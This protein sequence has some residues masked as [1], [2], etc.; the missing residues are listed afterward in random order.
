MLLQKRRRP[1]L[2]SM[3]APGPRVKRT[4]PIVDP[5]LATVNHSAALVRHSPPLSESVLR[6]DAASRLACHLSLA[7][8]WPGLTLLVLAV[9]LIASVLLGLLLGGGWS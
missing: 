6:A 5:R 8:Y 3:G 2:D 9:C 7:S 1:R 4:S